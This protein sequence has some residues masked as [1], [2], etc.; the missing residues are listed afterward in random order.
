MINDNNYSDSRQLHKVFELRAGEYATV[1]IFFITI[2]ETLLRGYV[3]PGGM[4]ALEA[5]FQ[6]R[7]FRV[8]KLSRL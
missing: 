6:T 4:Y 2:L 1:G 7:W 5:K 8:L 3:P